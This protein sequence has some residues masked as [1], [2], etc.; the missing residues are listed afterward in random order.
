V[1][2]LKCK[3]PVEFSNQN[4]SASNVVILKY[5]KKLVF[6]RLYVTLIGDTIF[7]AWMNG[8]MDA[9]LHGSILRTKK[10]VTRNIDEERKLQRIAKIYRTQLS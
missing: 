10:S 8:C 4:I 5:S 1:K 2:Y 6:F 9:W 3:V 7:D